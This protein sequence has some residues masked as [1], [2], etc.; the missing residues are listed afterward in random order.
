MPELSQ[1][2]RVK[3][4]TTTIDL[5]DGD[6]VRVTFDRN[7]ITSAWQDEN[8][9]ARG[10]RLARARE[11]IVECHPFLGRHRQRA[12]TSLRRRQHRQALDPGAG[13]PASPHPDLLGPSERRGKRLKRALVHSVYN[14]HGA[15]ADAP[16]WAGAFSVARAL[17]VPVTDVDNVPLFWVA[18]AQMML[19][20]E[21]AR[22]KAAA[23][24]RN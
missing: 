11:S 24:R 14:L 15:A 10:H 17:G 2:N 6:Q 1:L 7:K 3:P 13:S 23:A 21:A 19:E 12:G 22:D 4:M 20:A 16:E 5:G 8:Q 9:L 18:A